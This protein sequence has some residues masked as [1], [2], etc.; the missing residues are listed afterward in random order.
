LHLHPR[1]HPEAALQA[2]YLGG[3]LLVTCHRCGAPTCAI[4]VAP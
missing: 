3:V 1:C 2:A 4:E